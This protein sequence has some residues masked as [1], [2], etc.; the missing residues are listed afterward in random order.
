MSSALFEARLRG[1]DRCAGRARFEIL[2]PS[3]LNL[4]LCSAHGY[5]ADREANITDRYPVL[6]IPTPEERKAFQR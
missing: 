1:C 4:L 3:G 6:P 2:L 5:A